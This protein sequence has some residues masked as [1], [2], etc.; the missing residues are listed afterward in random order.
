M[1][2]DSLLARTEPELVC[3]LKKYGLD[4]DGLTSTHRL[5]YHW[6]AL[7]GTAEFAQK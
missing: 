1:W 4:G 6:G 3:D 7:Y 2:N 5:N